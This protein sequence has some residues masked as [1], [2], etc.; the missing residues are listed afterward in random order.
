MTA[1][2]SFEGTGTVSN[3]AKVCTSKRLAIHFFC[4]QHA[5]ERAARV[6]R[7]RK[8]VLVDLHGWSLQVS[9]N[10]ERDEFD[11]PTTVHAALF[12][13]DDIIGAFRAIRADEP[14]LAATKFPELAT[15]QSFTTSPLIWEIS[16]LTVAPGEQRFATSMLLYA[17]MFHFLSLKGG[18]SIVGFCDIAHQR[19]LERV[20]IET[21]PYGPPQEIGRD[22]MG[23]PIVVVAGEMPLPV[24]P[25]LRFQK[26]MSLIDQMEIHDETAFLGYS[27]LSA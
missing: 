13:D 6:F 5:P 15:D 3:S 11:L 20:G 8:E 21:R 18:R 7:F 10:E 12:R 4:E 19:L 1:Q 17:G 9:E 27:S 22:A 14:Y 24:T 23:R 26:L 16:R 25:S 2:S